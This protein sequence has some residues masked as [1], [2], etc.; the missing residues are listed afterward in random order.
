MHRSNKEHTNTIHESTR[1][2][3]RGV[4]TNSGSPAYNTMI[5][6]PKL[7]SI[8]FTIVET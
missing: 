6:Y 8:T 5:Y 7:N 2:Y 3:T 1:G 4:C